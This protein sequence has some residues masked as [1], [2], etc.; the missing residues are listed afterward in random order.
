M[1]EDVSSL[2]ASAFRSE[3]FG[4]DVEMARRCCDACL[5]CGACEASGTRLVLRAVLVFASCCLVSGIIGGGAVS[6]GLIC[7]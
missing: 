3:V 7:V 2:I 1:T 4:E 6:G 5:C